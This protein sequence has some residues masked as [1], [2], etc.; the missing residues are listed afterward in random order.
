MDVKNDVLHARF[1][2]SVNVA[3]FRLKRFRQIRINMLNLSLTKYIRIPNLYIKLLFLPVP[4]TS[5][6]LLLSDNRN[7]HV[8]CT[9]TL[10]INIYIIRDKVIAYL[11][12]EQCLMR[13]FTATFETTEVHGLV[14]ESI[15]RQ[16]TLFPQLLLVCFPL[17]L[18]LM[19]PN[20][21]PTRQIKKNVV[22]KLNIACGII[23]FNQVIY[24]SGSSSSE[25][26]LFFFDTSLK[27][28]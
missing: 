6:F 4:V 19:S 1:L 9:L 28:L 11:M 26:S 25:P 5:L 16:H 12:L 3:K 2:C 18:F 27:C 7:F 14:I 10:C 17:D 21:I 20:S 22:N 8:E 23:Y 15:R 24:F 13:T